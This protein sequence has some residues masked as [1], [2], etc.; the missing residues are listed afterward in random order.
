MRRDSVRRE[1]TI[2]LCLCTHTHSLCTYTRTYTHTHMKAAC[3]LVDLV[4]ERCSTFFLDVLI[5]QQNVKKGHQQ[6]VRNE[7]GDLSSEE[8]V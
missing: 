5:F 7:E 3:R 1:C 6:T 8:M 2:H 4:V